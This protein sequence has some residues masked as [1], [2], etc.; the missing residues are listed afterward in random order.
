MKL[1]ISRTDVWAATVDDR[2]GAVAEKLEALS[3]AG[4]NLAFIIARRAPE[5]RGSGVLFVTPVKGVRQV[6][7]AEGAGFQRTSSLHSLRVEGE[8]KPGLGASMTK[9]L[10]AGR[11][12]LR[13]L[14]AAAM[15]NRSVTYLALDSDTDAARAASILKKIK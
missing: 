11:I 15:G 8:D 10:A 12:N 2:P 9:A 6:R 14:S 7:A 1:S 13:G 4:V 3:A 5:Q